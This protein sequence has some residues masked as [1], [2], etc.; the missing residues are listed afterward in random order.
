MVDPTFIFLDQICRYFKC[1]FFQ[2]MPSIAT[3]EY[4]K[5]SFNIFVKFT[6]KYTSTASLNFNFFNFVRKWNYWNSISAS[7]WF[8]WLPIWGD[9]AQKKVR[10]YRVISG[11]FL[12]YLDFFLSNQIVPWNQPKKSPDIKKK[13]P[14]ITLIFG[15]PSR[16]LA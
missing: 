10:I 9:F 11:F 16:I 8:S 1:Q 6:Q 12:W 4:T 15:L 14:D 5:V 3:S 7:F 13:S 2:N